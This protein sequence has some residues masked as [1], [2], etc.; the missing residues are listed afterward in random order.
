MIAPYID[1]V[2]EAF[3]PRRLM[4]GSDWPIVLLASTYDRWVNTVRSA[5][6]RLSTFEQES[7]LWRSFTEAY[8]L[9]QPATHG[10]A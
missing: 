4:F 10:H 8:G 6:A 3:G 9:S 1:T 5:I 7:I 2:L